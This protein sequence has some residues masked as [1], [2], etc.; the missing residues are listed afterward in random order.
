[1][2]FSDF[3]FSIVN[4]KLKIFNYVFYSKITLLSQAGKKKDGE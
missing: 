4:L 3:K 1:M 2:S